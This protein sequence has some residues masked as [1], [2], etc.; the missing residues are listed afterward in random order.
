MTIVHAVFSKVV[1]S[2]L[3]SYE[4][5]YFPGETHPKK[6]YD[7]LASYALCAIAHDSHIC[8]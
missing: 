3:S 4:W 5:M 1:L 6:L 2:R 8:L 7:E